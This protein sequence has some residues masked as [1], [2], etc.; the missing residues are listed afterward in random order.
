M[1]DAA[2]DRSLDIQEAII[3]DP[4]RL[5]MIVF[6]LPEQYHQKFFEHIKQLLVANTH[7]DGDEIKEAA[8]GLCDYIYEITEQ[9]SFNLSRGL[10]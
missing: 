9:E 7:M 3:N 4:S 8:V 10:R 1:K 2:T 6:N 5:A